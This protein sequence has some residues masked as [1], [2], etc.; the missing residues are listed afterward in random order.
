MILSRSEQFQTLSPPF[1]RAE[2]RNLFN[3]PQHQVRHT[4][5]TRELCGLC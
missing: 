4:T 3:V 5:V 2:R 1:T